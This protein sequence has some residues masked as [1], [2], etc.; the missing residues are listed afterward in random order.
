MPQASQAGAVCEH[1]LAAQHALHVMGSQRLRSIL[2]RP[3]LPTSMLLHNNL[4]HSLHAVKGLEA[5]GVCTGAFVWP[6]S[7]PLSCTTH[8]KHGHSSIMQKECLFTAK[9]T[10]PSST[11]HA[12]CTHGPL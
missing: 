7:T 5:A 12:S 6:W 8:L 10:L 3:C 9:D 11:P 1:Q 2:V 4:L